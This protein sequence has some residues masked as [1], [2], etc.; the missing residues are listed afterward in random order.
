MLT[1]YALMTFG[2]DD[3]RYWQAHYCL[4]TVLAHAP[5]P[6]EVVIATDQPERFRWFGDHIRVHAMS[7]AGL[8]Q[9]KGEHG[10]FLRTLIQT[11]RLGT[12]LQ[13]SAGVA[14]YL[15][16]DTAVRSSLQPL[17][18]AAL[19]GKVAMDRREYNLH[20]HGK[21][22]SRRLWEAVGDKSWAGV[23][24]DRTTDM[25]N[26][27]ITAVAASDFSLVDKAL[28][29]CDA[30]LA[31]GCDHYLT[32]QIAMSAVL[33]QAGR[34]VEVN[35]P[36]KPPLVAHYWGNKD[37]W[38]DH[39]CQRLATI[40]LRGLSVPEAAAYVAA[41]PVTCPLVVKE[42]WWHKALGMRPDRR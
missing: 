40:H 42:R 8:A 24:V 18:D 41:N 12:A 5:R 33:G 3:F 38:N 36:G 30:M 13:P 1:R 34:A 2:P 26:T 10:Y 15:D 6:C 39:I 25:W 20:G 29:I 32:E 35:P 9:W 23:P 14:V 17:I 7:S 28:A 37:G 16:T 22:G 11:L 31:A 27:G 4:L 21:K 19:S